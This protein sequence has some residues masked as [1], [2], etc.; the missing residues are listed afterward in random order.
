MINS[1]NVK[2][3]NGILNEFRLPSYISKKFGNDIS[4]RMIL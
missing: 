4:E 1:I 2:T 3:V